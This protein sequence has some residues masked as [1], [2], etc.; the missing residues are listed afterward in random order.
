MINE[1]QWMINE[2]QWMINERQWM[3]SE[4][5]LSYL[6]RVAREVQLGLVA[7]LKAVVCASAHSPS[8]C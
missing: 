4:R 5:Q 3:I 6:K 7:V 8:E 2:R 1:R